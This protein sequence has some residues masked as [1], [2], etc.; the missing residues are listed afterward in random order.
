[1]WKGGD[2]P[3]CAIPLPGGSLAAY[4]RA[5]AMEQRGLKR[6]DE[7]QSE[8]VIATVLSAEGYRSPLHDDVLPRT[9]RAIRLKYR[10]LREQRQSH[11]REVAGHLTVPQLARGTTRLLRGAS[12]GLTQCTP[13][14]RGRASRSPA[15]S[16]RRHH[17]S[18]P[19]FAHRPA[20]LGSASSGPHLAV[21]PL[22]F[23]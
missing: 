15:R 18:Y 9:V 2:T 13:R 19:V 23:P 22:P 8:P 17:A 1:M 6:C 11:P 21:T 12:A 7:G 10:R 14:R 5:E 4:S 16:P 3:S 20:A